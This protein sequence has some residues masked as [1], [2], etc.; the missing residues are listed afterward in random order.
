MVDSTN[1]INDNSEE[2]P[3]VD[4]KDLQDNDSSV[5]VD[6]SQYKEAVEEKAKELN[7]KVK[8]LTC[9]NAGSL[10]LKLFSGAEIRMFKRDNIIKS[11]ML[12]ELID[13]AK[14]KDV[15]SDD[16]VKHREVIIE[17]IS[18][19]KSKAEDE[20][21]EIGLKKVVDVIVEYEKMYFDVKTELEGMITDL[22]ITC[23]K[24]IVN[25]EIAEKPHIIKNTIQE[26]L[27]TISDSRKIVI[28]VNPEDIAIVREQKKALA[29][30]LE[31][32]K[33]LK[34]EAV[35]DIEKGGCVIKTESGVL[36]AKIS[37]MISKLE[38]SLKFSN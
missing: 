19:I 9:P 7:Y 14:T 1:E 18:K 26:A 6:E 34:V 5:I 32:S 36:N 31:N 2:T 15:I 12:T 22:V 29:S 3:K 10:Y 21:F 30:F 35:E 20:G 23:V 13:M 16:N 25:E 27:K 4:D 28:F 33:T 11:D 24:K 38:E 8:H 37:S 17:E